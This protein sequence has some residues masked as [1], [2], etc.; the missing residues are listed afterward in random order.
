MTGMGYAKPRVAVIGRIR[1][2]A[3]HLDTHRRERSGGA[4]CRSTGPR[5]RSASVTGYWIARHLIARLG[6]RPRIGLTARY[7]RVR[8]VAVAG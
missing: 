1:R 5:P 2:S 6:T 4:G 3:V 8:L 7:V